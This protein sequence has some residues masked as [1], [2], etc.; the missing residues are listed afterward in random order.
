MST[1]DSCEAA[2]ALS[3]ESS[4]DE[5][6]SEDEDGDI[7]SSPT[8]ASLSAETQSWWS[9]PASLSEDD[10]GLGTKPC[11]EASSGR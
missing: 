10:L 9:E 6:L 11:A 7:N 3:L 1:T 5:S 8:D 2:D 4:D